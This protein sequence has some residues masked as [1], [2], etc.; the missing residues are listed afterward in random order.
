MYVCMHVRIYVCI[1]MYTGIYTCV[2]L[3]AFKSIIFFGNIFMYI[4]IYTHTYLCMPIL[5]HIHVYISIYVYIYIYTYLYI[6]VCIYILWY[7]YIYI[8]IHIYIY[9]YVYIYTYHIHDTN[10]IMYISRTLS[11]TSHEVHHVHITNSTIYM[12]PT[13]PH[14]C[15][16][17]ICR[18]IS[19][20]ETGYWPLYPLFVWFVPFSRTK[21][22]FWLVPEDASG[23][24]S[25]VLPGCR[26]RHPCYS[27]KLFVQHVTNS[28][29]I[30]S[31]M[32]YSD[33]HVFEW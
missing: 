19:F 4:C 7:I 26:V 28:M 17:I 33:H 8:Y 15:Q 21:R 3:V 6:Y 1:Y 9:M 30:T 14:T 31:S 27:K 11:Y 22:D 20:L 18:T 16:S 29:N 5:M 24:S 12:S 10:L 2:D 13:L 23:P 32:I 25:Q